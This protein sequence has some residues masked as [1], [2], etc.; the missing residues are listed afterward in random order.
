MSRVFTHC[1]DKLFKSDIGTGRCKLSFCALESSPNDCWLIRCRDIGQI[2]TID[3]LPDDVL[4]AIFDFYVGGYQ[5]NVRCGKREIESWQSLVQVCRRWRDLVFGSP[6]RLNLQ[7]CY[8][9]A[10]KSSDIWPALPLL[11]RGD[12]SETSVE[13]VIAELEQSD[14]IRQIDLNCHLTLKIEKFWTSMQ[15]LFLE[16]VFLSLS[17]ENS[18]VPVL[19]DSFLGGSAP[20]LRYL[21]LTSTSIPFPGLHNLLSST[22]HLVHLR[23]VNIPHSGCIL[24]GAMTTCLSM[25]TGL[26]SFQLEFESPQC[27]PDQENR[28]SSPPTRSILLV[29]TSFS[30]K[31]VNEYLEDLVSRIDAPRLEQLS[32]TFFNDIFF[33]TPELGQFISRT[34]RFRSYDEAHLV[35]HG[36]KAQVRLKVKP[37]PSDLRTVEVNILCQVSDWQLSSLVQICTL[38]LHLLLIMENLYVYEDPDSPP[39]W[40][41]DIEKTEWLDLLL[42]FTAV[43][44]LYVSRDLAPRIA[45]ALQELTGGRTTEVLPALRNVL[46]E[47]FHPSEPVHEGIT[48]FISARGLSNHPVTISVWDR[49]SI[50]AADE[51]IRYAEILLEDH[52][53]VMSRYYRTLAEGRILR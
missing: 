10:K 5:D 29:L 13:D 2:V 7:L 23:L 9:P 39:D 19:P 22:A 20:R 21:S 28:H 40:K 41:D 18:H 44:N 14:R 17:F 11:I 16:L 3:G 12:V 38:S 46:L 43:K 24:P 30:F 33:D 32:T 48:Q 51:L 34:P 31:G 26:E 53:A 36:H 4:L 8:K 45:P 15:V 27:C 37:K 50:N 47:R 49:L 6:R 35:F 42:P 25:L 52:K 1:V